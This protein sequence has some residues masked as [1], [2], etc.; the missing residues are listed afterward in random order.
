MYFRIKYIKNSEEYFIN[1][2]A[3]NF[4]EAVNSFKAKKIGVFIGA[5]QIEEPF[6]IK[7]EKLRKKLKDIFNTQSKIDMDEYIA[8]LEQ[9]YV[10]L[11]AS[12]SINDI[13]EE[14]GS[15]I[16]NKRLKF[17]I[18]SIK[19]DI[20]SGLSLSIAIKKFEK[21][22]GRLSI[23]MIAL[24]EQTGMLAESF[25]D[26]ATILHEIEENRKKLK[27]A[28]RY[29]V[30]IL[31]AMS[32]AFS[33]VILFVIP[34]FKSTFMQLGVELPL[35]TR[36]LLWL[37]WFLETFGPYILAIG[38]IVAIAINIAYK[39]YDKVR[40]LI[41]KL[42]LKVYI[43]GAVIKYAMLG[44]FLYSF[45]KMNAAGVPL[46]DSLDT[47]LEV[48]DNFYMRGR[49]INI[50][51]AIVEGKGLAVGF[52]NTHLFEKMIVQMVA[53]GE[54]SGN[55]VR[56]LNKSSN[57]YRS[58]YLNIVENISTLIEPILIA[59]IAGFVSVLAFGIFLPMW[60][61]ASAVQGH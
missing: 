21:D 7:V 57:Y 15:N 39:K 12:L 44:R 35:P 43:V 8:I 32:I 47:S 29:P 46:L 40:L 52:N 31:I 9:M 56:M 37:E 25:K 16:K 61:M 53:S 60:D 33:I 24:G 5:E 41:D 4:I 54:N 27:S 34:P 59:A 23:S 14:V 17:I 11:D 19:N 3:D 13:L 38:V 2:E 51:N 42:L 55:L 30:F 50:K 22:L 36:F 26:L 20:E 49:L 45:E 58:K 18:N 6:E 28:T 1:V 10:M 48:V